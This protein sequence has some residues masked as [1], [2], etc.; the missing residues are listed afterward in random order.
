MSRGIL[1]YGVDVARF[2]TN[3]TVR[4]LISGNQLLSTI[5]TQRE[6]TMETATR[7]LTD[8]QRFEPAMTQIDETGIGG[9]VR[10]LYVREGDVVARLGRLEDDR[11]ADAARASGDEED[12]PILP[13]PTSSSAV[14]RRRM[15]TELMPP[16]PN[17]F[18][19]Q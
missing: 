1:T 7:V 4:T 12:H 2:G 10:A 6:D 18:F 13:V 11:L 19:M 16:K 9:A 14:G 3:R 15:L 5:A 8:L 17:E